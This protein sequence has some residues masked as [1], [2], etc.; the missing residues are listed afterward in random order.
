LVAGDKVRE[1][2]FALEG[3]DSSVTD[4]DDVWFELSEVVLKTLK[5]NFRRA[6]V[7]ASVSEDG[8][9]TP[10]EVTEFEVRFS[11]GESGVA[12]FGEVEA[13]M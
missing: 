11:G 5:A 10:A 4:D 6:E 8:V 3:G 12:F 2:C 13:I 1:A 7:A 9:T